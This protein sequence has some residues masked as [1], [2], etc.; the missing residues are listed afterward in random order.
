M[1]EMGDPADHDLD[2]WLVRL[3]T[4]PEG[5]ADPYTCYTPLREAGP[6]HRSDLGLVVV[7]RYDD[8]QKVLRDPHFGKGDPPAAPWE[9]HG[10][11][12]T[13]WRARFPERGVRTMLD[14]DPPDH[15]RLRRLVA[16]AFTP[17]TVERLRPRIEA[18]ADGLLDALVDA[19]V[20]S[21]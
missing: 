2:G 14:L 21:T 5:K 10:L 13:A 3:L 20:P 8:C 1:S 9:A 7:G 12:E 19:V 18:L 11:T 6:V 4:T 16:A 17:R 15:T